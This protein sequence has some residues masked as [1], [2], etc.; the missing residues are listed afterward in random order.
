[1]S[2]EIK[3]IPSQG[4]SRWSA[5]APLATLSKEKFRQ[6]S[7]VGRAPQAVRLSSRVTVYSNIELHKWFADPV[8]YKAES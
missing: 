6:L 4:F 2:K 1:M 3:E 5:I 8:N 7:I